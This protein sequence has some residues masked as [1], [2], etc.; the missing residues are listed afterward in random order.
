MRTGPGTALKL[1]TD[2]MAAVA[3][4]AESALNDARDKVIGELTVTAP[5]A[6]G[7]TWLAPRLGAFADQFPDLRTPS[8]PTQRVGGTYSTLFTAVDHLER[9]CPPVS[10]RR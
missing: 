2:D 6:F 4:K 8:S 1:L 10:A 9:R 3:A 5:V 7:T